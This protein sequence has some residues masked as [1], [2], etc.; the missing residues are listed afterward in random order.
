MY[1]NFFKKEKSW[2]DLRNERTYAGMVIN[3]FYALTLVLYLCN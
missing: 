1:I 3:N 2:Q